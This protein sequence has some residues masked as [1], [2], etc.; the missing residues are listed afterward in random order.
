MESRILQMIAALRASGVRVSLAESGEAFQAVDLLGIQDREQFRLSLR[1][2]LIKEARDLP[3]FDKLFPLFFG[4]GQPPLMGGNPFDQLTPEEAQKLAE[5]LRQFTSQL[6][7]RMERLMNG[8]P[9]SRE[10]LEALAQMVG[11]NQANDLRYQNWMAQRMLRALAYPEVRRAMEELMQQLA[12]MGMSSERIQQLRELV[13]QNMQGM[14]QQIDQFAGERLAENLSEKE[15]ENNID[16]LLNRPFEALSDADKK[17][18]QHEVQR[19]AAALR[20]RI[21]L[22]QK[23]AKSGQLDPKA[24]IRANLKYQGVPI[25]LR[26]RDRVRKPRIVIFCDI[27]TSMRFCSE[28]MLS[29]LF[30]LQGQVHKTHAFAFIDHLESISEDFNGTNADEAISSVLVRMPSGYYNTDFGWSLNDFNNSY[31]DT[32]TGQTTM[33]VV[34]DGRNNHNDPR[35][36]LFSPLSMK[37]MKFIHDFVHQ[38]FESMLIPDHP[39]FRPDIWQYIGLLFGSGAGF[40]GGLVIWFVPALLVVLTVRLE[41]LPS[42]AH[43]RQGAKRRKLLA[44]HMRERRWRLAVPCAA[45]LL[46]A[47]AV[48]QSRFPDVEYWDPKPLPVVAGPAGAIFIPT[49]GEVDLEDGKMHKFVFRQEGR[50]ARFLVLMT[51]EGRLTLTLDACAICKPEGYGQAEGSVICFYCK[52]LIPLDTVGKP[53]GCNPVP[54]PFAVRE[55]GVSVDAETLLSSWANTAQATVRVKGE[56]K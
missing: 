30:A 28:L 6:R 45:V 34:G 56:G 11:L 3:T 27:S 50:E 42:V 9:L 7:E 38:F 29:F 36:D 26:H 16:G 21:A 23:H 32:L 33:I 19:L 5:A 52:T 49:K 2:T 1:A 47:A 15:P 48:W 46:L 18:L 17:M 31:M 37:V 4:S 35:I 39:F 41:R 51:P 10:E 54:V 55:N 20:T 43:L 14:Q 22:R 25:E 8:K 24:T 53:G 40:W 13:Q 12:Q 44:A